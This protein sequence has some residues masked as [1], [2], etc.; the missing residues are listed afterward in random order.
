MYKLL[1]QIIIVIITG[2]AVAG[3]RNRIIGAE[4]AN[5]IRQRSC[6]NRKGKEQTI[7][8]NVNFTVDHA[9]KS[10][11]ALPSWFEPNVETCFIFEQKIEMIRKNNA[12]HYENK[13]KTSW[14]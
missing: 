7:N 1:T 3:T 6:R 8:C 5:R 13:N 10:T 2:S 4:A 9:D 12:F 11:I 14:D